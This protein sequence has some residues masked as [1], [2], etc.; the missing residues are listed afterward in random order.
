M[1][2]DGA[3]ASCAAK[4]ATAVE[5]GILGFEMYQQG[6][7]FYNGEGLVAKGVENTID[8]ISRLGRVGM[9]ETDRVI[10]RMMVEAD[11]E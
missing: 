7:Q 10:I 3:K 2:C 8:N 9:K 5:A 4:I 11:Y 6:Q 1:V